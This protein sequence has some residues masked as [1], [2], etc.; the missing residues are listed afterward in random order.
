MQGFDS[1][2]MWWLLRACG[3]R[4]PL[5]R[6]ID[7]IELAIIALGILAALVATACAGALGT[8]VHDARSRMYLAEALTRHT[9]IATVI[10]DSPTVFAVDD[11]AVTHVNAKWQEDGTEHLDGFTVDGPVKAG[12]PLTIWVDRAGRRVNAPTPTSQAG[13]DAVGAAYTAWLTAELMVLGLVCWGRSRATR[14][15]NSGWDRDLRRLMGEN[16]R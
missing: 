7:R 6:T 4:H 13:V 8:A 15:R 16:A 14:R 9:V 2:H 10:A 12:D 11:N 3:R 1:I 5:V